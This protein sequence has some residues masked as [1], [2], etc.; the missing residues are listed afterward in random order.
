M[1]AFKRASQVVP[2]VKKPPA[3]AG[4]A[5][6]AGSIPGSGRS[7]GVGNNNLLQYS[8]LENCMDRGS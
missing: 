1:Y 5:R 6:D 8:C 4:G 7:L 3:G 2:V